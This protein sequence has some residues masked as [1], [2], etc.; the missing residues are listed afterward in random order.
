MRDGRYAYLDYVRQDGKTNVFYHIL[1]IDDEE[2]LELMDYWDGFE[3]RENRHSAEN[4][5]YA[6][7]NYFKRVTDD[8]ADPM[9]KKLYSEYMAAEQAVDG[10]TVDKPFPRKAECAILDTLIKQLTPADRQVYEFLFNSKM[11]EVEIKKELEL[12]HSAW[13]NRKKRFLEKVRAYFVALGYDV[14][15]VEELKQKKAKRVARL[16]EVKQ[17]EQEQ[18]ALRSMGKSIAR[19]AALMESTKRSLT[20]VEND[21]RLNS[22]YAQMLADDIAPCGDCE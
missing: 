12:E 22:D 10:E 14:P 19:E 1:S 13:T 15:T 9:D 20:S 16:D 17:Y 2:F 7:L 8:G 11:T 4:E 5:S 6:R 18:A 21:R 3:E